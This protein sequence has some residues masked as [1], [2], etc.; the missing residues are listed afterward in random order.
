MAKKA[1]TTG[2]K[3]ERVQLKAERAQLKAE[4]VPLKAERV[5]QKVSFKS[6]SPLLKT[7]PGWKGKHWR[8]AITRTYSF[9]NFCSSLAF[10]NYVGELA[11]AQDHH[12]DIDVRFNKVT[13]TLST[14]EAGGLSEKDFG[15]AKLIDQSLG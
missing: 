8:A 9:P 15:L 12:L 6:I 10:V 13:L 4:R 5:Q 11:E 3:A 14:H 2:L 7:V 1:A